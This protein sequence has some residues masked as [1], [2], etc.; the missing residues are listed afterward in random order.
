MPQAIPEERPRAEP[1]P[2]TVK[3]QD[4][5]T[6]LS[7]LLS[8][9]EQGAEFVIARGSTPVARL[10]PIGDPPARVMGF[11]PYQLPTSFFDPLPNDELDAWHR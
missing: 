3:V 10:V 7:S 1:G 9:V 11:V 8:K 5:K 6:R 2:A 4:A